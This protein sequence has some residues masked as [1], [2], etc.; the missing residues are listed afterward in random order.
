MD[1]DEKRIPSQMHPDLMLPRYHLDLTPVKLSHHLHS[2]YSHLPHFLIDPLIVRPPYYPLEPCLPQRPLLQTPD[3]PPRISLRV[4]RCTPPT[5]FPHPAPMPFGS[6]PLC[7]CQRLSSEMARP[8]GHACGDRSLRVEHEQRT[9]VS[10]IGKV[11]DAESGAEVGEIPPTLLLFASALLDAGP[12][13]LGCG[14][15]RQR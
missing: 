3:I 2:L 7:G 12:F 10:Q 5:L 4:R 13:R 14:A 15:L 11:L 9:C 1:N 8:A 6:D